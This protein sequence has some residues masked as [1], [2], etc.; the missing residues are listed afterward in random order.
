M[1]EMQIT[2]SGGGMMG[3]NDF[4]EMHDLV[5]NA[6]HSLASKILDTEDEGERSSAVNQ[7][8]GFGQVATK[9]APW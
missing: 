6:N 2:S 9:L 4:P 5:V 7:A 3:M 8:L 1:K